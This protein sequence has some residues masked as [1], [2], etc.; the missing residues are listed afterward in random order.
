MFSASKIVDLTAAS[1]AASHETSKYDKILG[2]RIGIQRAIDIANRLPLR[3]SISTNNN[4]NDDDDDDDNDINELYDKVNKKT[5]ALLNDFNNLLD[6]TNTTTSTNTT[7]S[8]SNNTSSSNSKK[9]KKD[10]TW[11]DIIL[12]QSKLRLE[13]ENTINKFHSRLHFG[14]DDKKASMRVFNDTIFDQINVIMNDDDRVIEKSTM[15]YNDS[16]RIDKNCNGSSNNSNSS[17][18]NDNIY[19]TEVYDDRP[20]YSTLL[21]TF[22]TSNANDNKGMSEEDLADIRKYKKKKNNVDRKASKGRKLRYNVHTK[23]QNFMFPIPYDNNNDV[24]ADRIMQ[25]LFQ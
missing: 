14:N 10:I 7:S 16:N 5:L 18:N 20:F 17:S 19:D 11:D 13:W 9:R 12:P 24:D 4:T 22:I 1:Q 2:L 6:T 21:K 25:S 8:N 15:P 23:L 3:S